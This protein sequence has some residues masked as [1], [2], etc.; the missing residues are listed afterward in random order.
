MDD[1]LSEATPAWAAGEEAIPVEGE[2]LELSC[3]S[4]VL[5]EMNSGTV[6]YEQNSTKSCPLPR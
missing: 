4:A 2:A 1:L 5:I 6:L 3:K